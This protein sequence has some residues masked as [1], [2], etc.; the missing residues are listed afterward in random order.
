MMIVS[1]LSGFLLKNESYASKSCTGVAYTLG[2]AYIRVWYAAVTINVVTARM[3]LQ[4]SF[5]S[6][7]SLKK[8]RII[9]D[10][11]IKSFNS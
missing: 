7:F 4:G 1:A 5:L 6:I 3:P 8:A 11:L 10:Y 9:S 2:V